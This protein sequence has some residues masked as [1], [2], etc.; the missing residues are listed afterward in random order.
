MFSFFLQSIAEIPDN[1]DL[2]ELLEST[3]KEN[4][5][6]SKNTNQTIGNVCHFFY[7]VLEIFPQCTIL[8]SYQILSRTCV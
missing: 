6:M 5:D 1:T 4:D 3:V 2:Q 7:D 8:C